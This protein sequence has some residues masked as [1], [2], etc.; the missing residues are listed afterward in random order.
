MCANYYIVS[1]LG[2]WGT[3]IFSE[4]LIK[5]CLSTVWDNRVLNHAYQVFGGRPKVILEAAN[6]I[7]PE[8]LKMRLGEMI[9][10]S[11]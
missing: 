10:R 2:G 3:A 11:V 1:K 9:T 5:D 8:D 4:R 7:L 6:N